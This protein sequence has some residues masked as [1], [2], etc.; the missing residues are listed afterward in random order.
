[1]R[2]VPT[3]DDTI[4]AFNIYKHCIESA[5]GRCRYQHGEHM[6]HWTKMVEVAVKNGVTVDRLIRARFSA[7]SPLARASLTPTNMYSPQSHVRMSLDSFDPDKYL[8]WPLIYANMRTL[9]AGTAARLGLEPN[10]VLLD[11][12][13]QFYAWFRVAMMSPPDQ[14]ILNRYLDAAVAEVVADIEL[15]SFIKEKLDGSYVRNFGGRI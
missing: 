10:F 8:D 6:R 2:Q 11:P 9:L 13:T 5:G 1:M 7:V 15:R 14:R 3:P 12:M 4:R